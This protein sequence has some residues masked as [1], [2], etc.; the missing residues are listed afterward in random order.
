MSTFNIRVGFLYLQ[1]RLTGQQQ[2]VQVQ[3]SKHTLTVL[4]KQVQPQHATTIR[5]E[6]SQTEGLGF[7]LQTTPL[8]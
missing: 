7:S 1:D 4:K 3:L 5:L 2:P 8:G 6:R